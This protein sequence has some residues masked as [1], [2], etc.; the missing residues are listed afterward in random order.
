[1]GFNCG[2]L[3]KKKG[4]KLVIIEVIRRPGIKMKKMTKFVS[5]VHLI[6]GLIEEKIGI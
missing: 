6:K 1:L 2:K 5:P 3:E 4:L